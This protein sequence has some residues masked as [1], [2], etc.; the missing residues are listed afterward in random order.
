MIAQHE[1]DRRVELFEKIAEEVGTPTYIYCLDGLRARFADFAAAFRNANPLI[2]YAVKANSNLTIINTLASLGAGADV[3][4]GGELQRSRLAGVPSHRIIFSGVGKTAA[5][6]ELALSEGIFQ[7]TVESLEE[8][9][10]LSQIAVAMGKTV[11]VGVRINPAVPGAGGHSKISTGCITTKFG[12]AIDEAAQAF[13]AIGGLPALRAKGVAIHIGSQM[14]DLK[15]LHSGL[16]RLDGLIGALRRSGHQV[17]TISVGGGLGVSYRPDERPVSLDAYAELIL[18]FARRW[19]GRLILEPGRWL[20]ADAGVLL[21]RVIRIKR[22][23][24]RTLVVLDAGMNDLPRPS[25]YDAWHEITPVSS[26]AGV[27]RQIYDVVGPLCETGDIFARGHEMNVLS[28]GELV[29]I[30]QAG[31]YC[32]S[33]AGNYNSRPLLAEVIVNSGDWRLSR[34]RQIL[35]DLIG[36]ETNSRSGESTTSLER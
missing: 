34:R 21:T 16:V 35:E 25:L 20:V 27:E 33:M 1:A 22:T 3:V 10:E 15:A 4:S 5:E 19:E 17:R 28:V 6:L 9:K 30:N 2:A 36:L 11:A 8:A 29:L 31:A 18:S 23:A 24:Q 7:V 14:M 26:S 13:E 32:S 12:I